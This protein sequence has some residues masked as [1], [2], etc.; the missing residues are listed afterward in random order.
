MAK[1]PV[2]KK[3]EKTKKAVEEKKT[4]KTREKEVAEQTPL[5]PEQIKARTQKRVLRIL[6]AAV[7]T[8]ILGIFSA[9]CV[10]GG[11][12]VG[13]VGT[14]LYKVLRGFFGGG[15]YLFPFVLVAAG[16]DMAMHSKSGKVNSSVIVYFV[17]L[18]LFGAIL[19]MFAPT[20]IGM[21]YGQGQRELTSGGVIG[22]F[23]TALLYDSIGMW[24][25]LLLYIAA[26]IA[27]VIVVCYPA[28]EEARQ[29]AEEDKENEPAFKQM[30][31]PSSPVFSS[32][33]INEA[34]REKDKPKKEKK[35]TFREPKPEKKSR[36]ERLV[37]G[38]E[39]TAAP[40]IELP[41]E[42]EEKKKVTKADTEKAE[43]LVAAEIAANESA[44][45]DKPQ[46]I[47][48]P[49]DLLT[50]DKQSSLSND[51][52]KATSEKIVAKLQSFG[53][54][55][56]PL[57]YSRGPAV[58][59]FEFAL[60]DGIRISRVVGL[61]SDIALAISASG[62]IR[63]EAPI[64][65]KS[66][67]GIEVPNSEIRTVYLRSLIESSEFTSAKSALTFA[68]GND[69]SGAN[70]IGDIA[71]MPHML[72]AGATG[73]GKSVCINS[74]IISALYKASPEDVRFIMVDPK[75][76]ELG[77]YNG[78]PHLL[79]PV[80]TD[81]KKA[82]GTLS[83]AVGE[84][85]KR[86]TTF[87]ECKVK[88]IASYNDFVRTHPGYQKMPRIVIVVD[89][90]ADL[91]MVAKHEVEQSICRLAQLARAAGMHLVIATQR[92]SVDVITGLI[93]ANIP[94]RIAFTV[95]S[96]V[97]SRTILDMAGA[98]KLLGRGDMLYN[99]VGAKHPSRVQGCW[100]SEA[101]INAVT[102]FVKEHFEAAYDEDVSK[103]IDILSQDNDKGK[104]GNSVLDN[105]EKA[106]DPMLE[107]AIECVVNAGQAATSYLQR[108]LGLGYARAARLIDI[109]AERGIVGP[110]QGSKPREVLITKEQ[111]MEMKMR[112][113]N[114][115]TPSSADS[116]LEEIGGDDDE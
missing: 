100:V 16:V 115:A 18:L 67:I 34:S 37:D 114:A 91:M 70:I 103:Q 22:G 85:T 86:Y 20:S 12:G 40:I 63:I 56:V 24:G 88:D 9:I 32:F 92:P 78:I 87:A 29:K 25:L 107:Q 3:E 74:L 99:P 44:Q 69:I 104:G 50:R 62:D 116:A 51:D 2:N 41:V 97:D 30:E 36:L 82:A 73:S 49:I 4:A 108:R 5:T 10:F 61:S 101:E 35:L 13:S 68:I 111:F 45:S 42:K 1:K 76:V 72:I 55:T 14:G 106:D 110:F 113:D 43:K 102:A 53:I 80:V 46:Y 77:V 109:M 93:K 8:V 79:V 66:A 90:L 60:A 57:A 98:E 59:R 75:M 64:P 27:C 28:F 21:L 23:I 26:I 15:A 6:I 81:P 89:E 39:E 7:F 84:M 52:I 58:T 33:D 83:W 96:I 65:G 38:D 105:D 11:S 94:S 112:G 47:F 19:Q 17:A 54:E 48:P 31:M 95:T 71:K